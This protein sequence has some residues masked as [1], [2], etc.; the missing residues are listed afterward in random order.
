M[1][2]A[3]AKNVAKDPIVNNIPL[4]KDAFKTAHHSR[5]GSLGEAAYMTGKNFQKAI[6]TNKM[7]KKMNKEDA[8]NAD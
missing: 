5:Q 4:G 7:S 8:E 1:E 3:I 6:P 2:Q